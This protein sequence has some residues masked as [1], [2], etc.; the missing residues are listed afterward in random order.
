MRELFAPKHSPISV[1]AS[2]RC[3]PRTSSSFVGKNRNVAKRFGALL[4]EIEWN[5]YVL[6]YKKERKLR[7]SF[8]CQKEK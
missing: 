2:F 5:I 1:S 3:E 4:D 6:F 7:F 8:D